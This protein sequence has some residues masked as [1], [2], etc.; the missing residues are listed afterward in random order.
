MTIPVVTHVD[1]A[2]NHSQGQLVKLRRSKA[3][4]VPWEDV[5]HGEQR[6]GTWHALSL[7]GVLNEALLSR[8]QGDT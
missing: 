7:I 3:R 5:A 8:P 4:P 2:F 1:K 6:S